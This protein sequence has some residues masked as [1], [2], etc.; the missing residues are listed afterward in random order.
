[1]IKIAFLIPAIDAKGP[2]IF[3]LNL[4]NG[5]IHNENFYC[6]VF[7]FDRGKG[8]A[9]KLDFPVKNTRLKLLEKYDFSGFDI[10]HSTMP[11]PDLYVTIHKLYL[12]NL[13]ITSL[14]NFMKADLY[15]RKIRPIAWLQ[16]KIWKFSL[17]KFNNI[18]VSS[19]DMENYY[20]KIL[21]SSHNYIKIPYGIPEL[22]FETIDFKYQRKLELLRKKYSLLV[23][24]GTLI[25]RKGFWQMINYLNHNSNAYVVLIGDGEC[26]EDLIKQAFKLGVSNRLWILGYYKNSHN[27]YPYFDVYC[28]CSNSEGFGLAM[29]EAMCSSLPIVCSDLD[30]YKDFFLHEQVGLFKYG[31]QKSFNDELDRVL[32]N[33]LFF[34]NSARQIYENTFSIN[35]MSQKHFEYYKSILGK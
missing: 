5:L 6:E 13:C 19:S 35:Q 10:I 22:K 27:L 12:T 34:A 15:Q 11:I 32:S 8:D 1:M 28:M 2:N 17:Q 9:D 7:H 25:K 33:K 30:I 31:N 23:G 3:T 29:L 18:I 24:C 4:I 26:R 21:K 14:H 20:K 16:C